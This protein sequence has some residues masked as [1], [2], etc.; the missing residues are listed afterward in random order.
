[1]SLTNSQLIK[2]TTAIDRSKLSY[3]GI[4][5]V[6]KSAGRKMSSKSVI[7]FSDIHC[8]SKVAICTDDVAITDQDNPYKP[9]KGQKALKA[10]WDYCIDEI[11]QKPRFL[12]I[13]GEPVEGGHRRTI[14]AGV[15]SSS[16]VDQ[17]RDFKKLVKPIPYQEIIFVRG[18]PYH[19]DIEGTPFEEVVAEML[20]AR[21]YRAYGGSGL[22][23]F[24]CNVELFG[25]HIN[26]THHVGYA[27]WAQYRPTAIS[28]ELTKMHFEHE[29]RGF[30]TDVIVRSH[31]HY[32]CEVR[33]P[34]TKGFSTP[35]WKFPDGFMY[36]HGLP[37]FPNIGCMEVIVESNG[38]I[39]VEP[40]L[41]EINFKP[42]ILHG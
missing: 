19:V 42:T 37:S 20:D 31:V 32:Y 16:L 36:R 1:M 15:Y 2:L 40:H 22:T 3:G 13:N 23:D 41:S 34:N 24:E 38:R 7:I 4:L 39:L 30:H 10:G 8:G 12:V 28:R 17:A 26:F 9:N 21:K 18:S 6:I 25:K 5:D 33:F 27:Q 14:G 35:A 29:A 11:I